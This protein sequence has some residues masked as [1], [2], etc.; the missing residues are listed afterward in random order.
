[1]VT[2]SRQHTVVRS[3]NLLYVYIASMGILKFTESSSGIVVLMQV[4][5]LRNIYVSMYTH[6]DVM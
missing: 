6:I 3:R 4:S 2:V 1:M 5:V